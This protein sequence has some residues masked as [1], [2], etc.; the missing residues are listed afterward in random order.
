MQEYDSSEKAVDAMLKNPGPK[1]SVR[2]II[3]GDNIIREV[4]LP[5]GKD[6]ISYDDF[7]LAV[8]TDN[9]IS[10]TLAQKLKL[11]TPGFFNLIKSNNINTYT[12]TI[13]IN[14]HY[15]FKF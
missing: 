6:T 1:D 9:C 2:Y 11:S 3:S 15:L 8:L 10:Q 4:K 14:I 5:E 12:I 13:I 7:K